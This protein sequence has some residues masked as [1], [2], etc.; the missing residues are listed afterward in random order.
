L[1]CPPEEYLTFGPTGDILMIQPFEV[2][3][4]ASIILWVVLRLAEEAYNF[5]ASG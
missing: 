2:D 5:V 4:F 3:T 1:K